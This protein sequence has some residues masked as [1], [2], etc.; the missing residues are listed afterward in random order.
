MLWKINH[1]TNREIEDLWELFEYAYFRHGDSLSH[2]L[3]KTSVRS[4]LLEGLLQGLATLAADCRP[5]VSFEQAELDIEM[6][7][8][9]WWSS[10]GIS[11]R[12]AEPPL[13]F[14]CFEKALETAQQKGFQIVTIR[15]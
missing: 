15:K 12:Y 13:A 2:L 9:R 7:I 5:A 4:A 11:R 14:N 10:I 6:H 1:V 8:E 3:L